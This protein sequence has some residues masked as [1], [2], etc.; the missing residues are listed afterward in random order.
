M[1]GFGV[2]DSLVKEAEVGKGLLEKIVERSETIA[3]LV[4]V[5][6]GDQDRGESGIEFAH[7]GDELITR[8][9]GHTQIHESDVITTTRNPLQGNPAVVDPFRLM[10]FGEHP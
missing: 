9:A 6:T 1:E 7:V 3:I 4:E 10:I 5:P 2:V 8:H